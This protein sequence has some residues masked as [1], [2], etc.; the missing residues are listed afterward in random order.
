[1]SESTPSLPVAKEP[2]KS[3]AKSGRSRA[4][5]FALQGL[6]QFLVGHNEAA[7]GAQREGDVLHG[8]PMADGAACAYVGARIDASMPST[9]HAHRA[10]RTSGDKAPQSCDLLTGPCAA[11]SATT[12]R[13]AR[14]RASPHP[15]DTYNEADLSAGT[16]RSC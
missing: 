15:V 11:L 10:T 3:A 6:Y 13:H 14:R 1:M 4:R 5:E 2:R 8:M 7:D 16:A 9:A 12:M